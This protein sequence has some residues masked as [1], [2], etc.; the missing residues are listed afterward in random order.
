MNFNAMP[1]PLAIFII[2]IAALI[3]ILTAYKQLPKRLAAKEEALRLM[4]KDFRQKMWMT[5]GLGLFFF[6]FYFLLLWSFKF[7]DKSFW[8]NLFMQAYH[9]PILFIYA[10]LFIFAFIS[11]SIYLVRMFIKYLFMT[12]HIK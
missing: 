3:L 4:V 8:Q 11:L 6:G 2:S 1:I 7:I 12:R 9:S 5:I 10:G